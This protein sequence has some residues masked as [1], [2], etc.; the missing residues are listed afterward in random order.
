MG[1]GDKEE[2]RNY[3]HLTPAEP[4]SLVNFSAVSDA[5]DAYQRLAVVNPIDHPPIA[6]PNAPLVPMRLQ[7]FTARG[8]WVVGQGYDFT[9]NSGKKRI[10]ESVELSLGGRLDFEEIFSHGN[11]SA[12]I[13]S[14]GTPR[15]ESL[16]LCAA[17]RK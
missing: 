9:I 16:F 2:L 13:G 5:G 3:P 1:S 15:M 6:Y 10:V 17:T 8:P 11:E 12:L 4:I 7:F 14:S